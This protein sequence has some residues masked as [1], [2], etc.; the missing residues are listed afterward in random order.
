M[1]GKKGRREGPVRV[2]LPFDEAIRRALNVK[3]PAGGWRKLD[4]VNRPKSP[5]RS[6]RRPELSN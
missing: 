2:D 4:K 1:T 5:K 3:P 6:R